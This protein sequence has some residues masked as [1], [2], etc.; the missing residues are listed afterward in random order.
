MFFLTVIM[1]GEGGVSHASK[2][3][4][5]PLIRRPVNLRSVF[6]SFRRWKKPQWAR[7]QSLKC[8]PWFVHAISARG[9]YSL[10][11]L[12]S[13]RYTQLTNCNAEFEFLKLLGGRG[14][15]VKVKSGGWIIP[16]VFFGIFGGK[17]RKS[18]VMSHGRRREIIPSLHK[19]I[20]YVGGKWDA[21]R[22]LCRVP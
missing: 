3:D 10:S 14:Q 5:R 19:C 4:F 20:G 2:M 21:G 11:P 17:K 1:R 15:S 6:L 18:S 12:P 13:I 7:A 22:A 16:A 8:R 9:G